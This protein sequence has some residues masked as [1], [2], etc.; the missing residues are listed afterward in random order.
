MR[1]LSIIAWM[2]VALLTGCGGSSKSITG[3]SSTTSTGTGTAATITVTS[4]GATIPSDGSASVT[5]TA[6]AKDSKNAAVSGATVSFA[7]SAGNI[8]VTQGTT[9]STGTATATLATGS[10]AVGAT[11]TVTATSGTASGKVSVTVANTQRTVTVTTDSPQIPSDGSKSATITALV[12]DAN[13]NFVSGTAVSF[14]STSGGLT[15]TQGTSGT[16]GAATATLSAAGDPSNRSITVTA[17]AGSASATIIVNVVGTTLTVTGPNSLVLGAAGTYSVTLA[18]SASRAIPNT[19]VTL[20][21]SLGNTLTP[22]SLTTN[23]G[24]S[25]SFQLTATKAGTDTVTATAL[26]QTASTTVVV[27]SQKFTFTAPAANTQIA[28]GQSAAATVTVNWTSGGTAV[29]GQAVAFAS[30][31]GTLSA[32]TATTDASGNASITIYSSSSGPAII[33]ATATGVSAQLAVDFIATVPTQVAVQASPATVPIKGQSTI[34][35]IVRDATGNLVQGQTVNFA[36]TDITGGSLSF[37]S[38]V[39][40]AQGTAQTVYTASTTPSTS[41]GVTVTATVVNGSG[42]AVAGPQSVDLTVGGQT[43]FLSLGTGNKIGENSPTAPT[44][45]QMPW[46]VQAV[47]SAGNPVNGVTIT[48]NVHSSL[49]SDNGDY[50]YRK[51]GWVVCGNSWVQTGTPAAFICTAIVSPTSCYNEDLFLTGVYQ[52]SEDTNGNGKLDPG[53]VAVATPGTV[54]TATDGSATFQ[55]EYPED[56]AQWVQVTLVATTTVQGT[57]ASTS[58]TFWLPIL[59]TY[60]TTTTSSPPGVVSPYGT[61]TSCTNPN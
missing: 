29:V 23:S 25:A 59:A 61:A 50:A 47:D 53:D 42:V 11:I 31:R 30:T 3:E 41:G 39:T 20:A 60:V 34:S 12:R 2:G 58:A 52:A 28:L 35:A 21:S 16:N 37:A 17:S 57:Q 54:T 55:V 26:G 13:N 6:V 9:D 14:T 5:I 22:A 44:Q 24:G 56:H 8:T 43:V 45:F 36:L 49:K 4:S 27:S 40:D 51:G 19:A 7:A 10:A 15:V 32:A 46:V 18:D 1:R 33:A 38:V 48:L